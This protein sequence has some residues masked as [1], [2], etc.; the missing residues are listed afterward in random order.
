MM[1]NELLILCLNI[2]T[3]SFTEA[4]YP[5]QHIYGV[6]PA[7][8]V[9]FPRTPQLNSPAPPSYHSP[10]QDFSKRNT[11]MSEM[12][13]TT[14]HT[15]KQQSSTSNPQMSEIDSSTVY[16]LGGADESMRRNAGMSSRG[17]EGYGLGLGA[18]LAEAPM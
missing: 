13:S 4:Y 17:G 5:G 18:P 7:Q 8:K 14:V 11:A 2:H 16:E 3:D 10:Q 1:V 15:P 9:P 12:D 6:P